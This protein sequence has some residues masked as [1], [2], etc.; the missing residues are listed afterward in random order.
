M[1]GGA[2]PA[3]LNLKSLPIE[4][5]DS[6]SI[7]LWTVKIV[8][9]DGDCLTW[10]AHYLLS[11]N[12]KEKALVPSF[13]A[14]PECKDWL[15]WL[16]DWLAFPHR[17]NCFPWTA[18]ASLGMNPYCIASVGELESGLASYSHGLDFNR[19][20]RPKSFP[21]SFGCTKTISFID[22]SFSPELAFN[23]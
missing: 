12:Y 18:T 8:F 7:A 1:Y 23:L 2:I 3:S 10:L 13:K 6:G 4:K 19:A 22:Y 14:C 21:F 15:E 17:P 9:A 5:P 20:T 11:K 16:T